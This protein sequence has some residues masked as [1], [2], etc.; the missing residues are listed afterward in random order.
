MSVEPTSDSEP[1][2]TKQANA[3]AIDSAAPAESAPTESGVA[4][5]VATEPQQEAV[6]ETPAV[7]PSTEST[8]APAASDKPEGG[9]RVAIGSQRD[10]AARPLQ[11]KA[12]QDAVTNRINLSN[13]Q[14]ATPIDDGLG[15]V[16]SDAGLGEDID[17]EIEA[18]L[19][20]LSMDAVVEGATTSEIELESGTRISA[21]V[22][23]IHKTTC[24]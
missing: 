2:E 14:S 5:T 9:K 16:L 19:G 6:A 11:P 20:G 21:V 15:D 1:T 24:S 8:A 12:V 10:T 17:A 18:A 3:P 22:S 7:A 4:E 13:E 23:K